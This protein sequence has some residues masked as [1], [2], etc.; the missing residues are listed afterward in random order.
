MTPSA[1]TSVQPDEVLPDHTQL[2]DSD[3]AIVENFQEHPQG[4]EE[5]V[6]EAEFPLVGAVA[7]LEEAERGED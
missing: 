7:E 5:E 4:E 1:E 6:A 3:G 2:P